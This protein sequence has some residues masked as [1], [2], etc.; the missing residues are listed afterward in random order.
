MR[1]TTDLPDD[2][3]ELKRRLIAAE[4]GLLAKTLEAEKLKFELARLR[5]MTFGQSSERIE[6]AIEQLELKLERSRRPQRTR[7]RPSRR[8][9]CTWSLILKRRKHLRGRA[10]SCPSI[11]RAGSRDTNLPPGFAIAAVPSACARSART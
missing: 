1:S 11:C 6:R 10:A 2:M 5:R 3:E 8:Q 7:P 4:A 9:G